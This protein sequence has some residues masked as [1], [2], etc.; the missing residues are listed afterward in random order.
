MNCCICGAVKNVEQYLD[1]ILFN[2]EQIGS[3]FEKY[4]IIFL[5]SIFSYKISKSLKYFEN[6]CTVQDFSYFFRKNCGKAYN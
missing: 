2:I 3:L 6:L 1:K 4:T 5:N